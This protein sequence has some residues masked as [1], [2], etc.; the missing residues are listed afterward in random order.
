MATRKDTAKAKTPSEMAAYNVSPGNFWDVGNFSRCSKRITDSNVLL[1]D[2]TKMFAE[3]AEIEAKYSKKLTDWHTRWS[4]YIESS[5][6]TY[7][8]MKT[9][10]LGT[11]QEASDRAKIHMDCWGKIHNQV[12]EAIKRQK[13]SKY[14]KAFVGIKEAKELE[15]E[16]TKAQKPWA[17]AYTKVQKAKK[18]YHAACKQMESTQ[19][20]IDQAK[21][22]AEIPELKVRIKTFLFKHSVLEVENT[23]RLNSYCSCCKVF[24]ISDINLFFTQIFCVCKG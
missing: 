17:G 15:D 16:Y 23:N 2:L 4:K 18:N 22:D 10:Q 9:A 8:T 14:H 6:A 21:K 11:L 5:P 12:V 20:A 19:M 3:R 24:S 13:E 1:D 7:A